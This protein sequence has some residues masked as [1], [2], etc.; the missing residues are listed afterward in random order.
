[1]TLSSCCMFSLP[2]LC[3]CSIEWNSSKL[4]L[5]SS[6]FRFCIL[7]N[8]I[9]IGASIAT[10]TKPF[11]FFNSFASSEFLML[12]IRESVSPAAFILSIMILT[13]IFEPFFSRNSLPFFV[14]FPRVMGIPCFLHSFLMMS[15]HE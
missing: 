9:S 10:I 5:S 3:F 6:L 13:S 1:M 15:E 7:S 12:S 2:F 4:T 14:R 8:L 11:S